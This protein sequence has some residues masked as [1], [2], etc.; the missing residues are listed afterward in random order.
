MD[1]P[2]TV[3]QKLV[4]VSFTRNRHFSPTK[5]GSSLFELGD[6][7]DRKELYSRPVKPLHIALSY[8]SKMGRSHEFPKSRLNLIELYEQAKH[9]PSNPKDNDLKFDGKVVVAYA[10]MF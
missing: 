5:E 6:G 2:I 4:L 7:S 9:L 1:K 3:L 10:L 8:R